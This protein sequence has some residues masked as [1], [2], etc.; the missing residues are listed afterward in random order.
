MAQMAGLIVT[1]LISTIENYYNTPL[2]P[3]DEKPKIV[4]E[5]R[6]QQDPTTPVFTVMV[7]PNDYEDK[8]RWADIPVSRG[9]EA[10]DKYMMKVYAY[11]VGG[12]AQIW[13]R[14]GIIEWQ[15]FGMR[16][17]W[18]ADVMLNYSTLTKGRLE[19]IVA[20]LDLG[21][22]KDE[23]GEVA[24]LALPVLSNQFRSGGEKANALIWRGK[25]R[26][27]VLTEIPMPALPGVV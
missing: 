9:D 13:W 5:G 15:I 14:R 16:K 8:E 23:F 17:K 4:K 19:R 6:L 2:I 1:T 18:D 27:Q 10:L 3:D 7:S 12:N 21:N 22:M 11:E 25:V 20:T 26:Y 24:K